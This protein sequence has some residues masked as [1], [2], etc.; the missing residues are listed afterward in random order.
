[1]AKLGTGKKLTYLTVHEGTNIV[2][3]VA[4]EAEV[5]AF[6][7][8]HVRSSETQKIRKPL[9]LF[10]VRPHPC[11]CLS[12]PSL[13]ITLLHWRP[14]TLMYRLSVIPQSK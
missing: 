1:M 13:R 10:P 4:K 14:I 11:V 5:N 2:V 9:S 12:P 8:V 7:G 6:V 3:H